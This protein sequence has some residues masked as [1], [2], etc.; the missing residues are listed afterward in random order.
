M[1]KDTIFSTVERQEPLSAFLVGVQFPRADN[2]DEIPE[3]LVEL[4]DLAGTLGM[5]VAGQQIVRIRKPCSRYL[6]GSGKAEEIRDLALGCGARVIIFDDELTPSQQRNWEQFA[7]MAVIDRQEV[8]LDIFAERAQTREAELQVALARSRY[9]MPRLKRRWGHLS[10]QRGMR[11]GMGSR[12]E[13]EQQLEVDY[14]LVQKQIQRL[15]GRLT[16]VQ[17]QRSVQRSLRLRKGV[18]V[19]AIVG[20][21]NAGKSA[22]LNA[23]TGAGVYVEDKLFATLDPTVRNLALPNRREV[24]L[25]DTVGFIRKLPHL[26]IEAF[27]ATLEETALADLLLEVIDVTAPAIEAHHHTTTEV[28]GAIGVPQQKPVLTVFNKVD[29]VDDELTL[30]R[31]ERKY[32]GAVFVSARTGQGLDALKQRLTEELDRVLRRVT[33]RIP[34]DR[35]DLVG[36]LYRSG[37]VV[38][39]RHEP[40]GV[41]L[42]IS[43][44]ARTLEEM[45][46]FAVDGENRPDVA[47]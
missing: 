21:T 22:L 9:D 43:A 28:L 30:R 40:E 15:R 26:L 17:Q 34:H 23:L 36:K 47:S 32:T 42:D 24:L 13:G 2:A 46:R 45:A 4:G 39:Q 41:I 6:V 44:P 1:K 10:R 31:L 12:G 18:P 8:I 37:H 16:E 25:T 29:L 7:D 33:L 5:L 35:Y 38:G 14:R 3:L 19:V 11:G 20:Y 27:K